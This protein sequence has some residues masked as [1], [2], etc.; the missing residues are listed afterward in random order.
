MAKLNNIPLSPLL[1]HQVPAVP[2]GS[3]CLPHP[4][5]F[6]PSTSKLSWEAE[7]PPFAKKFPRPAAG[8]SK[9]TA[10]RIPE[11]PHVPTEPRATMCKTQI[12]LSPCRWG[13]QSKA[14][15]APALFPAGGWASVPPWHQG[16]DT[17]CWGSHITTLSCIQKAFWARFP[18]TNTELLF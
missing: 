2:W 5:S 8:N 6:I 10:G 12:Q 16:K 3:A 7:I 9:A 14:E 11:W 1:S 18:N 17:Q 4:A 13:Y 15:A